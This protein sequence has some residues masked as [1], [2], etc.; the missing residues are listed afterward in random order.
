M[1]TRKSTTGKAGKAKEN[2]DTPKTAGKDNNLIY[3]N[4][5][6]ATTGNY[7]IPPMDEH[8]TAQIAL[9]QATDKKTANMLGNV[10]RK[11]TEKHL[12]GAFDLDL[13]DIT[14]A[15]WAVVFHKDE[16]ADVKKA[17][18]PLIE[19]RKKGIGNDDIVKVLEYRDGDTVVGWLARN[20]VGF[21]P[22]DPEK[23]PFTSCWLE[24]PTRFLSRSGS[25][26][27]LFMLLAGSILTISPVINDM[28][29][30]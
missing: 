23:V 19:H 14:Q 29:T 24:A 3:V 6:D 28:L 10:A 7:L 4:G 1:P 25:C 26:W 18:G 12:G 9:N 5:I 27:M 22:V 30:A 15:G 20:K 8:D 2:T 17:L 13:E 16:S 11:S 21:G